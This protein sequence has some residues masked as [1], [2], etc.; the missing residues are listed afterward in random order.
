MED[1]RWGTSGGGHPVEDIRWQRT[2]QLT[3]NRKPSNSNI[4]ARI[5]VGGGKRRRNALLIF[6]SMF[7]G[8]DKRKIN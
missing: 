6:C 1:I 7:N 8:L 3:E 4:D 2:E 5:G